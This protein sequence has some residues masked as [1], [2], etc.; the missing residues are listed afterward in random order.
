MEHG[1]MGVIVGFNV[2]V[3][4]DLSKEMGLKDALN[5]FH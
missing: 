3:E 2:N 1:R 4:N 5:G